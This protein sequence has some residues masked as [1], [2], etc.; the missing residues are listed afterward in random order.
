MNKV[1]GLIGF[2]LSHSFSEQY[3]TEKFRALDLKDYC[4]RTFP[5]PDLSALPTLI[6]QE[7]LQ[8]FNV[9]IPYKTAVLPYLSKLTNEAAAIGA[10]NTV[11]ISVINGKQELIG[12][13]T[14]AG[15]F[16][17]CLQKLTL[18]A[19]TKALV[20]G[21]G[22][23]SRAVVYVLKKMMI[24]HVLVGRV[25]DAEKISYD[26]L[27]PQLIEQH[28]LIINTTPLGMFPNISDS[29]AIPYAA[30]GRNHI[31]YDLI[32]N[33]EQTLFLQ[34]AKAQGALTLNGLE[35]LHRQADLAWRVWTELDNLG[36]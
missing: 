27:T 2:P 21:S 3:F 9:T 14:D 18:Q 13:N 8:G 22:G 34:K 26:Q 16:E 25:A 12:H 15:A 20:L 17:Q 5:L 33:P 28:H 7:N 29:P 36:S 10:V 31:A 24:A 30:I 23:A 32:Y 1:Y 11:S 6:A 19:N 4:Y 35:M